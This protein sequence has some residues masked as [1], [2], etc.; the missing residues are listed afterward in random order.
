MIPDTSINSSN[1]SSTSV[2]NSN[3]KLKSKSDRRRCLKTLFHIPLGARSKSCGYDD[4]DVDIDGT[5]KK[6][7]TSTSLAGSL[8]QDIIREIADLL[9]PADILSFS[10]TVR[11][12]GVL[13]SYLSSR[14]GHSHSVPPHAV[15][16]PPYPPPSSLIRHNHP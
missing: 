12:F 8:P 4:I 7:N 15:I 2:I 14:F 5:S 3:L 6:V 11:F 16:L 13:S 10:L 1:R 9:S